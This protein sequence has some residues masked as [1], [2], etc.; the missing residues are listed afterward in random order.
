LK[1]TVGADGKARAKPRKKRRTADD[2]VADM[3]ARKAAKAEQP[4]P[5]G[6]TPRTE[7]HEADEFGRR[8]A[9]YAN[10]MAEQLGAWL[11]L[12]PKLPKEVWQSLGSNLNDCALQYRALA[13][14]VAKKIEG[15]GS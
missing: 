10:T 13:E 3:K 14:A 11:G 12:D 7:K 2:F 9:N 8:A 1:K 15:A 4:P 5:Q 6:A